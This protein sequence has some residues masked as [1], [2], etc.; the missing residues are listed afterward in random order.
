MAIAV[1]VHLLS[2]KRASL[3]VEAE[4]SVESLKRRA[5]SALVVP[6][7]GKLVSSSGE[8]LDGAQTIKQAKLMSGA[9][10]TLHVTQA[11][12]K[13]SK[14]RGGLYC[15]FAARLGD[16]SVVSWS[17]V[18]SIPVQHQ[19]KNV[20]EIKASLHAFAAIRR[21]GS[22]VTWGG[23]C[24]GGDS[25]AVKDQLHDVQ[26]I[27][28]SNGAFAAIR[29][30]GSVVT[31][32]GGNGSGDSRAVQDQLHDVQQIQASVHAFAAIRRNGSVVTWGNA[33]FGG[34]SSPVKDQLRDV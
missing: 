14:G 26:Q 20:L 16:G 7:P 18:D 23:A 17:R 1:E 31:W 15:S 10:L 24:F 2:G 6:G 8:V 33:Q 12:L 25:S 21:N 19:L 27:Q 4:A 22:V 5:Q 30:D 3:E 11:Q 13:A 29:G 34:D 28:A 9:V 32:G